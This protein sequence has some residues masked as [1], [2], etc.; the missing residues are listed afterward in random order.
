MSKSNP[1]TFQVNTANDV[2]NNT[3][4]RIKWKFDQ[5]LVEK[6]KGRNWILIQSSS[7]LRTYLQIC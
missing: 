4:Q 3:K 5:M 7:S 6:G 1:Q 2:R